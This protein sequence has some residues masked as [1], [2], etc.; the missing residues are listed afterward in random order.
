MQQRA[1]TDGIDGVAAQCTMPRYKGLPF[2]LVP[3]NPGSKSTDRAGNPG[4][5]HPDYLAFN[6]SGTIPAITDTDGHTLWESNAILT[7]L[8]QKHGWTD[9]YPTALAQR[10]VVDQYLHWHHRN[11]R[12]ASTRLAAPKFR[13]DL[14]FPPGHKEEGMTII[15]RALQ[16][17]ESMLLLAGSGWI[18]GDRLTLADFAC[19][20]EFGQLAPRFGNLLDFGPHPQVAAWM[21]RM[22][23]LPYFEEVNMANSIIGDLREGVAKETIG[24][25][26]RESTAAI[27][28]AVAKL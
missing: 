15:R 5:R 27:R 17:L 16:V 13:K 20:M 12:E 8:A 7:Y 26:N 14:T 18:A 2:E 9:L 22:E 21:G 1:R 10:S 6:P 23:E 3:T 4:T 28:G 25:A 11:A 24:R 19:Y